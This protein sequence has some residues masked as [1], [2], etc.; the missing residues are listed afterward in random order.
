VIPYFHWGIEY[1][2]DPTA[3]QQRIARA[4]ID[5]GADMVLGNHPHWTQGI[6][7]YKGRLLIYSFGNFIFDQD[8][9]RPTME[10]MLLHLYWRGTTLAGIRFVPVIDVDRCQP[11]I[12]TPAEA[13]DVFDRL[14]SGTD[15]LAR[16]QY[17][18]E[19]E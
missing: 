15:M 16:G 10:G 8:W 9:S 14:W 11:R 5:A 18:P 12:M 17:G 19:P 2:K 3:E 13:Q 1:T 7:T 6:E 4:A